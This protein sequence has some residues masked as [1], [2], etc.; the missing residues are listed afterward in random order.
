M[1]PSDENLTGACL[2]L[3][4]HVVHR[5]FAEETVVLNLRTARYHGLNR[6]GG[7]MLE[8]LT[9]SPDVGTA[10]GEIA[11]HYGQGIEVVSS[12]LTEF[13]RNLLDRGLVEIVDEHPS[14]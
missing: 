13:C 7:Y 11:K 2:R 10:A 5:S 3:P 9:T 12:D 14:A 1:T 6:S 4:D 8:V